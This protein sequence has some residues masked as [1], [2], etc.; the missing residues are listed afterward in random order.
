METLSNWRKR[1]NM[2]IPE[3]AAAV[4][5]ERAT[6]WRWENGVRPVGIDSLQ[7]VAEVTGIPAASL[8]PDIASKLAGAA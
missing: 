2:S 8:R 5:V 4:G 7:R 1:A 6:W 3:A